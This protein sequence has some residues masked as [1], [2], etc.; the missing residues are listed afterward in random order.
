MSWIEYINSPQ[1]ERNDDGYLHA[2]RLF[3]VWGYSRDAIMSHPDRIRN[4][5]NQPMLENSILGKNDLDVQDPYSEM[6]TIPLVCYD[7]RLTPND[8]VTEVE[9]RYSNDI[10]LLSNTPEDDPFQRIPKGRAGAFQRDYETVPILHRVPLQINPVSA[11]GIG[12]SYEVTQFPVPTQKNRLS[13]S[14]LIPEPLLESYRRVVSKHIGKLVK[15]GPGINPSIMGPE[16][17]VLLVEGCDYARHSP[18]LQTVTLFFL[19]DPGIEDIVAP[20]IPGD[21]P[22]IP[23]RR[24]PPKDKTWQFEPGVNYVRPPY[25]QLELV[26]LLDGTPVW[27]TLSWHP[28]SPTGA[29]ELLVNF[30]P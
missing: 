3:K 10:R 26:Y 6:D 20:N 28:Y 5:S 25:Q 22:L 24:V 8:L 18:G 29:T 7:I 11:I 16:D 27:Q 14:M 13:Y 1:L 23:M 12:Y 2:T 21:N 30:R 15:F 19:D 9:V 4:D 17:D